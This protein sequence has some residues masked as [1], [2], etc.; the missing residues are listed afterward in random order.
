MK[1][2]FSNDV[3]AVVVAVCFAKD[4]FISLLIQQLSLEPIAKWPAP[5][6][7]Y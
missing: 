5:S 1:V 7:L 2:V 3:F 6:S 4:S